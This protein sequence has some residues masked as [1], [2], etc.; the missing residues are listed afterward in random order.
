MALRPEE[1]RSRAPANAGFQHRGL[2]YWTDGEDQRLFIA[3]GD[4]R[5]IALN[6]KTGETYPDFGVDG[7]GFTDTS[8]RLG[9]EINIRNYTHNSPV[10]V[11]GDTV[12]VGSII[13]DG[14]SSPSMPPG[15]VRGYDVRSGEMKWIF[16][17]IP[18]PGTY[19]ATTCAAAK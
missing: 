14:P 8:K 2:E 9:R 13:S 7:E 6:A 11:C 19:A 17:T 10:T 5:L 4:R 3:T 18:Q 1:L 16:H 12:V 15:H